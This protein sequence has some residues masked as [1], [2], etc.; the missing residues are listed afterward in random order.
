MTM[1]AWI[2]DQRARVER[3]LASYPLASG[4]CESAAWEILPI[5]R[6]RDPE[7]QVWQLLPTEGIYVVPRAKLSQFW[8][9]HFTVEV[10]VHCVDAL[11]GVDGAPRATYLDEYWTEVD[12][13]S[14]NAIEERPHEP[15]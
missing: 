8:F 9:H 12:A 3:V 1:I 6:E 11:T 5:G 2:P 7:A 15:W 10:D 13:I 14:W 4:R